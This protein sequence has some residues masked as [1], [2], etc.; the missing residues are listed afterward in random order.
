[1]IFFNLHCQV[2]SVDLQCLKVKELTL[3]LLQFSSTVSAAAY[4]VT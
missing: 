4:C 1:M 3:F 2:T